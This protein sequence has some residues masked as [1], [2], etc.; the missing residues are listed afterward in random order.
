MIRVCYL[1]PVRVFRRHSYCEIEIS[2][3]GTDH[4]FYFNTC[5]TYDSSINT[6]SQP[7]EKQYVYVNDLWTGDAVIRQLKG[8][9]DDYNLHHP[10]SALKMMSPMEY[11][12]S[13]RVSL[14][15]VS[16]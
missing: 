14:N 12:N 8:W 10:H 15:K 13:Q 1:S 16:V 9:F 7:K 2:T 4:R 3:C 5:E 6:T 11:R